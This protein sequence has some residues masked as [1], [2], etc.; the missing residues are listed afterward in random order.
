VRL[1]SAGGAVAPGD[2]RQEREDNHGCE[3]ERPSDHPF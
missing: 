3:R 2:S 1:G